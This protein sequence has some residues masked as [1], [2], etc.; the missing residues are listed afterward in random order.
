[1][2]DFDKSKYVS[3]G[4]DRLLRFG[5]GM[6]KIGSQFSSS[7]EHIKGRLSVLD[8]ASEY[9]K[10]FLDTASIYGG[11]FSESIVGDYLK[12]KRSKFFLATK[13]YPSEL[14]SKAQMERGIE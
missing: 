3:I 2:N 13:F 11:G 4:S 14:D 10:I 8:C 1:M 5:L 12:K 9:G 6:S 7:L